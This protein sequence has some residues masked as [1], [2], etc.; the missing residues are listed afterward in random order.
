MLPRV[1]RVRLNRDAPSQ[2]YEMGDP[3]TVAPDFGLHLAKSKSTKYSGAPLSQIHHVD[4]SW[5]SD[6]QESMEVFHRRLA[7]K[8]LYDA[9][10]EIGEETF[11]ELVE[12]YGEN[13]IVTGTGFT[14]EEIQSDPGQVA[15]W[16]NTS[17]RRKTLPPVRDPRAAA[18]E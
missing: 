13:L 10:V 2:C 7:N 3:S 1:A 11:A 5:P 16:I 14:L 8:L 9:Y 15:S 4:T 17:R 12:H 18:E 6:D